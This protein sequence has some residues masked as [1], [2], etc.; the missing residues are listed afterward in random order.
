MTQLS[1][2]PGAIVR[3]GDWLSLD[4]EQ[5]G[6]RSLSRGRYEI[7]HLGGIVDNSNSSTIACDLPSRNLTPSSAQLKAAKSVPR[8]ANIRNMFPPVARIVTQADRDREAMVEDILAEQERAE[9]ERA[10]RMKARKEQ[11]EARAKLKVNGKPPQDNPGCPDVEMEDGGHT[12]YSPP[13]RGSN[14]RE[15]TNFIEQE[16]KAKEANRIANLAQELATSLKETVPK[17]TAPT[18]TT[19]L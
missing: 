17:A 4:E 16:Q 15:P 1:S 7:G 13:R 5:G 2:D 14:N 19:E 9:L 3:L 12:P 8:H 18:L 11:F 6:G 10:N